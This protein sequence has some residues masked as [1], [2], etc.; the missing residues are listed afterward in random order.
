[1]KT[2]QD[3]RHLRRITAFKSLFA[4][5]FTSQEHFNQLSQK[6]EKHQK[7]IDEIVTKSATEWPLD[8]INKTDI[9]ILRLAI[10]ELMY[11]KT[12]PTKVIID[13]A[14]EIAKKYGSNSSGSFI[15]GALAAALKL[16]NRDTKSEKK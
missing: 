9:A 2:A 8:Q 6:V 1:M 7:K 14:I 16:T 15:N 5:N 3:P 13:E 12:T 10:Y 4:R 11:Q